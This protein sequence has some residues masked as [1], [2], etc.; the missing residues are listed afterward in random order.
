[1][2]DD[3]N[4]THA[5]DPTS[6]PAREQV[7]RKPSRRRSLLIG[8]GAALAAAVLIG[9]GVAV[10]AAIADDFETDDDRETSETADDADDA[11]D[12]ADG[13]T[14]S[15]DGTASAS[16]LLDIIE[17]AAAEAEGAPVSIENTGEGVWDV[18]FVTPSGEETEVRVA[19]D[20]SA[21]VVST[22]AADQDDQAP[23]TALDAETLEALVE[24]ALADTDGTVIDIEIDGDT[25]SPYDVTVL[26]AER[27]TVD[28]ALDP[29]FSVVTTDAADSDD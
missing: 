22:E 2:T 28:I 21:T 14:A 7:D 13:D 15:G 4:Q 29:A 18:E 9:G 17:T 6:S 24:A 3:I 12:T 26:T 25:T 20:A 10:G 19:A 16:E 5:P 27:T 23:E 11:D 1:M 8:G